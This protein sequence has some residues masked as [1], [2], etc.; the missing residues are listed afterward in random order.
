VRHGSRQ[1]CGQRAR[2]G[3]PPNWPDFTPPPRPTFA[4]PLTGV[5]LPNVEDAA[6]M[7]VKLKLIR[8]N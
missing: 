1:L 6:K 7:L 2:H 3:A 5:A 8:G 4:P